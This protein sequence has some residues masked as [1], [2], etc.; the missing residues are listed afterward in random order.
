MIL[1]HFFRAFE[2]R[3]FFFAGPQNKRG[4]YGIVKKSIFFANFEIFAIF[5]NRFMTYRAYAAHV[6]IGDILSFPTVYDI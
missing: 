4:R 1:V 2:R 6:S 5:D 3:F